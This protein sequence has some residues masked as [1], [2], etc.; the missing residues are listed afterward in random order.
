VDEQFYRPAEIYE[1]RGDYS[2][3]R[4]RFGWKPRISFEDLV[5]MMVEAD[6][7]RLKRTRCENN[8][9]KSTIYQT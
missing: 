2:K 8:N 5:K 7:E 1:L 3:A 9:V 4:S 6:L